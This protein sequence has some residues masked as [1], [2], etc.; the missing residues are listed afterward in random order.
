M[1]V[2]LHVSKRQ[3]DTTVTSWSCVTGVSLAYSFAHDVE[4]GAVIN[5][6][7]DPSSSLGYVGK[8]GK[9]R[10]EQPMSTDGE[11]RKPSPL[12]KIVFHWLLGSIYILLSYLCSYYGEDFSLIGPFILLLRLILINLTDVARFTIGIS[13][14]VA[15]LVSKRH[16]DT[17]VT[18]WSCVT[19]VSLA[20]SFAH[21][22]ESGAVIP[23]LLAQT[24]GLRR[25]RQE[26]K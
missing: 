7:L 10:V 24:L 8:A 25:L 26:L 22:V 4:S 9:K 12:S 1:R 13:L 20:Y 14:R 17:T 18:S 6:S 16:T 2:A 21:D 15:L 5:V 23:L 11:A 3:C 19:G